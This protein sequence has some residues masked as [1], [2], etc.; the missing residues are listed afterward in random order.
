G[1]IVDV[2]ASY[3]GK[4]AA[5]KLI[6]Q[7]H[8]QSNPGNV[9]GGVQ[10]SLQ[11]ATTPDATITWAYPYD[12]TVFP[13]GVGEAPLMWMN[14]AAADQYYVHVIS[15]T[16]QLETYV[17]AATGR[18]DFD[19]AT[20]REMTDSISGAVELNVSRWDGAK[21]TLATDLHWTVAPASMR[22]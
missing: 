21:A 11:G 4:S 3:Q 1:G 20:W 17:T 6:V 19:P 22:G 12:A 10:Q 7:L 8:V 15:P 16:F 13:R 18:Y 2:S 14:G 9:S 5:A